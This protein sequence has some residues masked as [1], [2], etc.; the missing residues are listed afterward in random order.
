MIEQ[1]CIEKT[2]GLKFDNFELIHRSD[3]YY[4]LN[5][6]FFSE[7]KSG[8]FGESLT[9]IYKLIVPVHTHKLFSLSYNDFLAKIM[10]VAT[11]PP[12]LVTN[13]LKSKNKIKNN[14]DLLSKVYDFN[15][16]L[17]KGNFTIIFKHDFSLAD[18]FF[19]NMIEF[20]FTDKDKRPSIMNLTISLLGDVK[21][22]IRKDLDSI[23]DESNIS[24]CVFSILQ[25]PKLVTVIDDL[26]IDY[27]LE[28][29]IK[30]KDLLHMIEY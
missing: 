18:V 19:K 23:H 26:S 13:L 24:D 12:D 28:E 10:P 20:T 8:T 5:G 14:I 22:Q 21:Y 11:L 15:N 7:V 2:S 6:H 17:H 9:V 27:T 25:E 16:D 3:D 4:S 29:L 1:K 30:F